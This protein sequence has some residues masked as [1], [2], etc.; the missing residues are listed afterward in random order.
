[1]TDPTFP[2]DP[3]CR[4][5]LATFEAFRRLGFPADDIFFED[6][7]DPQ[8]QQRAMLC[9]LRTQG[10][11]FAVI[12]GPSDDSTM[13]RLDDAA[14]WWNSVDPASRLCERIWEGSAIRGHSVGF[15]MAIIAKGITLPVVVVGK[16]TKSMACA[17]Q[18][19]GRSGPAR[20]EAAAKK[21][22]TK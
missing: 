8:D 10:K 4:E 19:E 15:L 12:V 3:T 13:A 9:E 14:A 17:K 2:T 6:V 22:K 16:A 7:I 18:V 21:G 1:M 20:R 11:T 5:A